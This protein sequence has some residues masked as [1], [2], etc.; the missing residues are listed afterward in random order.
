MEDIGG[1]ATL[2]GWTEGLRACA[3]LSLMRRTAGV[4]KSDRKKLW[5]LNCPTERS[6]LTDGSS[7]PMAALR[8][9]RFVHVQQ[10]FLQLV[11][12]TS[13]RDNDKF[14]IRTTFKRCGVHLNNAQHDCWE[15]SAI[16]RDKYVIYQTQWGLALRGMGLVPRLR[17]HQSGPKRRNSELMLLSNHERH[18]LNIS[19]GSL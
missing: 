13:V 17:E 3:S 8:H 11:T 12:T 18:H 2:R 14:G 5:P 1:V 16:R 15:Q 9:M 10:C 19:N 4:R 6:F 7:L